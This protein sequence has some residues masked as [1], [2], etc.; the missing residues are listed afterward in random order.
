MSGGRFLLYSNIISAWLKGET[1]IVE[2]IDN[3]DNIYIPI[4]VIGELFYGANYSLQ[5]QKNIA[6]IKKIIARYKILLVD[7]QTSVEY[8]KVKSGLWWKRTPTPENDIWIAAIAIQ[9]KLTLV[10]RD[11]HFKSVT[12]LKQKSW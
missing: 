6:S 4:V 11:S 5:P 8:G 3:A 10:S 12:G 7:I 2:A 9:R 1:K